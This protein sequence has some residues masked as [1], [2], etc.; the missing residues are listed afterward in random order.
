MNIVQHELTNIPEDIVLLA[1]FYN[2]LYVANFPDSD[3]RESLDNMRA[4]ISLKE[5]GW[6]ESNNYHILFFIVDGVVAAASISDYLAD[7]NCGVIEFILVNEAARGQGLGRRLHDA[8]LTLLRGDAIAAGHSELAAVII[9]LNDPFRTAPSSDN[10][11]PFLRAAMW[12]R[13]GYGRLCFPYIQPALSMDQQPV[14]TLLLAAKPLVPKLQTQVPADLILRFVT[15]YM[16]WAMRI[17]Q[18]EGNSSYRSMRSFLVHAGMIRIEP[19]L[20]YLGRDPAYPLHVSEA[21]NS[22]DA[23][24][25][26]AVGA[27][28]RIFTLGETTME[29]ANFATA[30]DV[31]VPGRHYHLWALSDGPKSPIRGLAAFA[32]TK[33]FGFAGYIG[34]EA[35]LKGRKLG[36]MLVRRMEEQMIRDEEAV[37]EWYVEC[38]P[39][40]AEEAAFKRLGFIAVPIKYHQPRLDLPFTE[41][42]NGLGPKLSLMRKTIGDDFEQNQLAHDRAKRVVRVILELI[43]RID[44]AENSAC[45]RAA[46]EPIPPGAYAL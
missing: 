10:L 28:R 3:E 42:R 14:D 35:E 26:G 21:R 5:N 46:T 27:Y 45:Y 33:E 34:L 12:G 13:W 19:L 30:V 31:E 23:A 7:A 39:G 11:D 1:D 15:A 24:F 29:A 20:R 38:A 43:Y 16:I 41:R 4:Y 22:H 6:Y 2:S 44:D 17:S 32:T 36:A 37:R 40:T 18:P 25:H 8:T 9:E